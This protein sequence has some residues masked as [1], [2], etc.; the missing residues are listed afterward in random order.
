MVDIFALGSIA[1][2]VDKIM[3]T[4]VAYYLPGGI[5]CSGFVCDCTVGSIRI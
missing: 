4:C 5:P 1:M 2:F 3:F